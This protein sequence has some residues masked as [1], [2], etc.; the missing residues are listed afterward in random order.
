METHT[1]RDAGNLLLAYHYYL[2][3]EHTAKIS[4]GFHPSTLKP[5]VVISKFGKTPMKFSYILWIM[6]VQNI[7]ND[8]DIQNLTFLLNSEEWNQING[9]RDFI[10]SHAYFNYVNEI[11]VK[12]Y[13]TKYYKNCEIYNVKKLTREHFFLP[14]FNISFNFSKL[15]VEIPLLCAE[16]VIINE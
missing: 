2:N 16:N 14:E 12:D 7:C 3:K 1:P 6:F 5:I 8:D 9:I 4:S 13:I 15:F 10:T 11:Y